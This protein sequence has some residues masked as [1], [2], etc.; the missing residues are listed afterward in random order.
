MSSKDE[1]RLILIEKPPQS[2]LKEW[3]SSKVLVDSGKTKTR[4]HI[5]V[6]FIDAYKCYKEIYNNIMSRGKASADPR[7]LGG[8]PIQLDR[9]NMNSL[10]K[11]GN[12]GS[13]DYQDYYVS[14]KADGLRFMLM[15]G[16]KQIDGSLPIYFI[17]SRMNFWYIQGL[18]NIPKSMNVDRA[19]IDGELLFWGSMETKYH[20]KGHIKEYILKKNGK[21]NP[22]ISFLAFDIL[23]GPINPK[24]ELSDETKRYQYKLG[25]NAGMVGPKS[26]G[27]TIQSKKSKQDEYNLSV[28]GIQAHIETRRWPT[29]RRRHSLEEMFLNNDSPLWKFLHTRDPGLVGHN[30]NIFVSPFVSL[31]ELLEEHSL[32]IY[33]KMIDILHKSIKN[34]YYIAEYGNSGKI[35]KTFLELP[36]TPS[37]T[38]TSLGKGYS[39]DGLILTPKLE[40]YMVMG[41]WSFCN[42]K[43]Y[44][45]KPANELNIDFKVG[46][47]MGGTGERTYYI[48]LINPIRTG[49]EIPKPVKLEYEIS[50]INYI[51]LISS[52]VKLVKDS[53][54]E[55]LC[56][57]KRN[58]VDGTR[59]LIFDFVRKRLDKDSPNGH[60]TAISTLNSANVKNEVEFVFSTN[61]HLTIK[62]QEPNN[63]Y[64]SE[65]VPRINNKMVY[66]S[67]SKNIRIGKTI[68]VELVES[69]E[70][71]FIFKPV[72]QGSKKIVPDTLE[73]ANKKFEE[74][75]KIKKSGYKNI[76]PGI[77]DLVIIMKERFNFLSES[78]RERVLMSF[79]KDKLLK[80]AINMEPE[81]LFRPEEQQDILDIISKKQT[82]AKDLEL[83]IQLRLGNPKYPY[84]QCLISTFLGTDYTPVPIIKR[85]N[86]ND[87]GLRSI[88]VLLGNTL[89]LEESMYKTSV[90]KLSYS[91]DI[92]NYDFDINLSTEKKADEEV[93]K[94]MINYQ[95]RYT[96]TTLSDFWRLDIIESGS[97]KSIDQAKSN[98]QKRP[99]TRIEVEY[100]PG[101]YFRDIATWDNPQALEKLMTGIDSKINITDQSTFKD[102]VRLYIEELNRTDPMIVLKDL[103]KVL[104]KIFTVLDMD[105]GNSGNRTNSDK[106]KGESR[107]ES[108]GFRR[109]RKFNNFVKGNLINE[110][111]EALSK[112]PKDIKLFDISVGKGGDIDKWVNSGI[113]KVFGIDPDSKSIQDAKER[114]K[115][116][117]RITDQKYVFENSTISDQ[118]YK[119]QS[120]TFDIVSCQFTLHYFFKDLEM[121]EHV[122]KKVGNSLVSGGYFIGTTIIGS[123][124]REMNTDEVVIKKDTDSYT[125]KLAEP[126]KKEIYSGNKESLEW[127]VDFTEFEKIC[128]KFGLNLVNREKFEDLYNDYPKKDL[129]DHEKT[130]AFMYDR[131]IFQK[132]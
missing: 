72:K 30:F 104:I 107:G 78:E 131:F 100:D 87:E 41:A 35:E 24:Y 18:P 132:N 106:S 125:F 40:S 42:N 20:T 39:S 99:V 68:K 129:L 47:K 11:T 27:L 124:I 116:N 98:W 110:A 59:Y 103:G 97:G 1:I 13:V 80:C 76:L 64:S 50:G 65:N 119:V 43:Q 96:V 21:N 28:P 61:L 63:L 54:V 86:S 112:D 3:G 69:N 128:E 15:F 89:I 22:F 123:R 82:G 16:N 127:Y 84:S 62:K 70:K 126:G 71:G 56:T 88:Y 34:Q 92:Y 37:S 75:L 8:N 95:N 73:L 12:D 121:L 10:F 19:L 93:A 117:K 49:K 44:K 67:S 66:I 102:K 33:S 48:G 17:D 36:P 114:F 113:K 5:S 14:T 79:G 74:Q 29:T 60:I 2:E 51:G 9:S 90:K 52:D 85:F 122:V 58:T 105:S 55:C 23:Y 111:V 115:G 32:K 83:E 6:K 38:K 7:F 94:G 108:K 31:K 91:N 120:G 109:M 118:D 4:K 101:S 25:N 77:M 53:I 45:W 130:I 81:Q 46:E 26:V 57:T